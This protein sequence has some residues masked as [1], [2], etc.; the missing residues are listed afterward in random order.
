MHAVRT[1]TSN[2][3]L[4]GF[5]LHTTLLHLS[6]SRPLIEATNGNGEL[7]CK[8]HIILKNVTFFVA[9]GQM[10]AQLALLH[11]HTR[12]S[13]PHERDRFLFLVITFVILSAGSTV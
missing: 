7:R 9:E 10:V 8:L 3:P 5:L 6:S 4:V 13:S 11:E 12:T 1:C 2:T